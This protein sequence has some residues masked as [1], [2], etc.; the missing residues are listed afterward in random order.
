MPRELTRYVMEHFLSFV[1]QHWKS[2]HSLK[3]FR[4]TWNAYTLLER[5]KRMCKNKLLST[6]TVFWT[7]YRILKFSIFFLSDLISPVSKIFIDSPLNR[8][9]LPSSRAVVS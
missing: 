8:D 5:I 7:K 1:A 3:V 9:I 2:Q 6:L 4:M